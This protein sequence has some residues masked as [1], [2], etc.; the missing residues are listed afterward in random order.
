MP[1]WVKPEGGISS[2]FLQ[3][4]MW[5]YTT[6]LLAFRLLRKRRLHKDPI[7]GRSLNLRRSARETHEAS[8]HRRPWNAAGAAARGPRSGCPPHAQSAG[9][10]ELSF[11]GH[12]R[13]ATGRARRDRQLGGRAGN[14]HQR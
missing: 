4:Y 2:K 3:L 12:D 10:A 14:R 11:G 13:L 9:S 8:S 7:L 6:T 5:Y 1:F